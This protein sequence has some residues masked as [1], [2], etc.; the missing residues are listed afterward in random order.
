MLS[1]YY[2]DLKNIPN[3]FKQL[4]HSVNMHKNN[5]TKTCN[6]VTPSIANT[7]RK[8]HLSLIVFNAFN[9]TYY[10]DKNDDFESLF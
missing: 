1:Q 3:R 5:S 2:Q 6:T 10:D 4:I 7:T 9:S 8:I